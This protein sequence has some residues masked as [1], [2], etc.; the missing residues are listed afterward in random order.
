MLSRSEARGLI[1]RFADIRI[2]VVGDLMLDR[3]VFG[4][5]SRISPEAPVPVVHVTR[6]S[7]R[8]GGASNVSLNIASM[9]GSSTI[10][11]IIGRDDAG[12][13]LLNTFDTTGIETDGIIRDGDIRT[14]VK[15]RIIA[16]RQQVARVDYEENGDMHEDRIRELCEAIPALVRDADAVILEDYG[17]GVICQQVVDAVLQAAKENKKPVG[18]DPKD[19]HHLELEW[20]TLATPNYREAC[21]A[22]GQPEVPLGDTPED[23]VE[24]QAAGKALSERWGTEFLLITLGSHGMYLCPHDSAPSVQPTLAQEVFDV[25]GA[26]DTVIAVAMLA[27]AAG[28]DHAQAAAMANH[29]AGVVVG[30]VG[31]ATCSPA[32]L[33]ASLED[34]APSQEQSS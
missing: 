4:S 26:G 17:K 21:L 27:L 31:T 12:K 23:C 13:V 30:K 1:E 3:Y 28:A 24:L 34:G 5:V 20:L 7:S 11:G 6:E 10:S 15:T 22:T 16:E 2:L 29:A 19:N 25:S 9:G 18:F 14:T 33:L 8:P 32:E